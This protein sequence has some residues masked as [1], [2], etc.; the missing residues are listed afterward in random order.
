LVWHS[1]ESSIQNREISFLAILEIIFAISLYWGIAFYYDFYLHII[2][3]IIFAPFLLLKSEDSI[4]YT[5]NKSAIFFSKYSIGTFSLNVKIRILMTF[6]LMF[7]FIY[8]TNR[9]NDIFGFICAFFLGTLFSEIFYVLF[10]IFNLKILATFKYIFYGIKNISLNWFESCFNIDI[11]KT[12]ELI[13]G[14]END[15][16]ILNDFKFS[17]FFKNIKEESSYID[18]FTR[19][20]IMG[21]LYIFAIFYRFSIK[22]TF[23]FY[24]PLL[25]L[26]KTPSVI[27]DNSQKVGEFLSSLY[28]TYL[29]K[30]RF[31]L[32]LITLGGFIYSYFNYVDFV[33][34]NIP[35]G[36]FLILFYIDISSFEVWRIFQLS[37]VISTIFIFLGANAIRVPKISNNLELKK[38]L[39]VSII[40]YLNIFRNWVSFLYFSSAFLYLIFYFDGINNINLPIGI[41][42]FLLTMYNFIMYKPFN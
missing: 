24:I 15:E 5:L 20:F 30:W 18:I 32:A 14:I 27:E 25:F 16:R 33:N 2:T 37:I 26:V 21:I 19:I 11:L 6:I 28:E 29:A 34:L 13:W 1:S 39:K 10:I 3:S 41:K 17:H 12:P 8:F 7:S 42:S 35:F 40:F 36:Q 22:S 4:S 31:V 23:W 38:D 9:I